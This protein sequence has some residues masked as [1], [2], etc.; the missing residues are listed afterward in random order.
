MLVSY[1]LCQVLLFELLLTPSRID[2]CQYTFDPKTYQTSVIELFREDFYFAK[3]SLSDGWQGLNFF[4]KLYHG[5]TK[6]GM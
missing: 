3:K 6:Y 1:G 2:I 4:A 5:H